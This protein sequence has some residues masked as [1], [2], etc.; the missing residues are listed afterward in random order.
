MRQERAQLP[1]RRARRNGCCEFLSSPLPFGGARSSQMSSNSRA[2]TRAFGGDRM[3]SGCGA[4]TS[5]KVD[6]SSSPSFSSSSAFTPQRH[7]RTRRERVGRR[8]ERSQY[9]KGCARVHTRSRRN[10]SLPP[11]L[12]YPRQLPLCSVIGAFPGTDPPPSC[13]G[14]S[15]SRA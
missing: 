14:P 7:T 4:V 11:A 2:L 15:S 3:N 9:T 12:Y 1:R 8:K 5:T 13:C 6:V 10:V